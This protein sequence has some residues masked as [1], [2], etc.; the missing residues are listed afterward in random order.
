[1][2]VFAFQLAAVYIPELN[3]IKIEYRGSESQATSGSSRHLGR[4]IG[5]HLPPKLIIDQSSHKGSRKWLRNKYT[6]AVAAN[7]LLHKMERFQKGAST[8]KINNYRAN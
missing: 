1:V 4:Q 7:K 8:Q 3:D 6:G 2:T 5:R